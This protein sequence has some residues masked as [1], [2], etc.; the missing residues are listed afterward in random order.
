MKTDAPDWFRQAIAE[1][2]IRLVACALPGQPPADT[3]ALTR[4]VWIDALWWG[5]VWD[6][7]LDRPRLKEGFRRLCA[8][9]ERWPNPRHLR[10]RLPARP[11]PVAMPRPAPAVKPEVLDLLAE[12]GALFSSRRGG[13]Q[14]T[15]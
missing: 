2:L 4:E 6:E 11:A 14:R 12:I 3:I 10:D 1:G 15:D 8:E 5:S 7:T 9:F 13:A